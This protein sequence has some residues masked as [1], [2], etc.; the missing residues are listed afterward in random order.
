M[1]LPFQIEHRNSRTVP[2]LAASYCTRHKLIR[3]KFFDQ[4]GGFPSHHGNSDICRI[5]CSRG[6]TTE[7]KKES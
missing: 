2:G 7:E 6:S 5:C 4:S 3:L 1:D